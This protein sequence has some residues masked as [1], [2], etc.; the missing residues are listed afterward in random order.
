MKIYSVSHLVD[1]KVLCKGEKLFLIQQMGEKVLRL[2]GSHLS[3]AKQISGLTVSLR[4]ALIEEI[5]S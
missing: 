1:L 3:V 5:D 2:D 4:T